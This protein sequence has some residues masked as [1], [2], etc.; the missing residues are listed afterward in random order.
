MHMMGMCSD[1]IRLP[2]VKMTEANREKLRAEMVKFGVLA[3]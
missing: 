3:E 1:V 2:L